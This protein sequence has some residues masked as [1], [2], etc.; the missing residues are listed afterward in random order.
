VARARHSPP[1]SGQCCSSG[2]LAIAAAAVP[3][4]A[5]DLSNRAQWIVA[6]GH[7]VPPGWVSDCQEGTLWPAIQ[8]RF[9]PLR[10][11]RLAPEGVAGHY[12]NGWLPMTG[13]GGRDW[14]GKRTNPL[15]TIEQSLGSR[16]MLVLA[17][18]TKGPPRRD[19][20]R[21]GLVALPLTMIRKCGIEKSAG[22]WKPMFSKGVLCCDVQ[23]FTKDEVSRRREHGREMKLEI[24]SRKEV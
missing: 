24:C 15:R 3:L 13:I 14:A 6:H 18:T 20:R 17:A 1:N 19:L 10:G 2:D 12:R 11:G 7:R 4:Q 23:M 9:Y 5:E 16:R 22:N 21:D 8:R